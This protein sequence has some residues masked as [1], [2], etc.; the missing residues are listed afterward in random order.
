MI[1]LCFP[2]QPQAERLL[3]LGQVS[4]SVTRECFNGCASIF[5]KRQHARKPG[6]VWISHTV[7]AACVTF[8]PTCA[9][10]QWALIRISIKLVHRNY[11]QRSCLIDIKLLIWITPIPHTAWKSCTPPFNS[12]CCFS[13]DFLDFPYHYILQNKVYFNLYHPIIDY[14]HWVYVLSIDHLSPCLFRQKFKRPLKS[15]TMSTIICL[16]I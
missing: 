4:V 7:K 8:E 11:G 5:F 9:Y 10:A 1:W 14:C 3:T 12:F 15:S 6:S 16:K 2:I 13:V